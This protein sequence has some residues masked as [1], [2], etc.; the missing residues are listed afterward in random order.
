MFGLIFPITMQQ[1]LQKQTFNLD[2][3]DSGFAYSIKIKDVFIS[4]IAFD[5]KEIGFIPGTNTVR[6]TI[7][8]FNVS[9]Q[10]NGAIYALQFIPLKT[11]GLNITNMSLQIDLEAPTTDNVNW[12]IKDI[13]TLDIQDF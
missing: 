7:T 4:E 6:L 8:G 5:K 9:S 3:E 12:Q 11:A 10:V 1:L 2:F 13:I